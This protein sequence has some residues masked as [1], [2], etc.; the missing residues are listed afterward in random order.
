MA[1]FA[2]FEI[3]I[4]DFGAGHSALIYLERFTLNY[5]KEIDRSFIR[6]DRHGNR[7]L[8]SGY[9]ADALQTPEYADG[10]RERWLPEQAGGCDHGVEYFTGYWISR[11]YPKRFRAVDVGAFRA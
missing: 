3:A 11:L 5:L 6:G 7:R 8:G 10:G 4:D 9:R 2:G 1:A